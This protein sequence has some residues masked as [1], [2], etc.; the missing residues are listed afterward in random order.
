MKIL[1]LTRT[2]GLVVGVCGLSFSGMAQ[3][4]GNGSII[5][6]AHPDTPSMDIAT[7][8]R[9]FLGKIVQVE[10]KAVTPVNLS[11]GEKGRTLFMSN[12]LEQDDEKFIGYWT[13]RRYIGRGIPPRELASIE[14][15]I[16]YLVRTPG[17][18]GYVPGTEQIGEGVKVLFKRP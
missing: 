8:Q 6:I 9:V 1:T 4:N 5:V 10:G 14:E 2:I 7:V 13:V 12:V 16:Q 18:I 15:M 11:M 17:A 3:T